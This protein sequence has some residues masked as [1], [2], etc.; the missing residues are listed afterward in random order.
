MDESKLDLVLTK[1]LKN[2]PNLKLIKTFNDGL[3][4]AYYAYERKDFK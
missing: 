4:D 2:Q 3:G 1:N